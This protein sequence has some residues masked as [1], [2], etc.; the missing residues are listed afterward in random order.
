MFFAAVNRSAVVPAFIV[1]AEIAFWVILVAGLAARYVLGK[2]KLGGILLFCVPLA[3]V[4][5]VVASIVDLRTGGQAGM[6]HS[7]AA[8]YLGVSIGFGPELVRRADAKFAHRFADGRAPE[9]PPKY[10]PEKVRYEW[11]MWTRC[12]IALLISCA[13]TLL[14]FLLAEASADP[15]ALW[16]FELQLAAV[17]V[18]WLVC[19]PLRLT[20][21]PPKA[22]AEPAAR[23]EGGD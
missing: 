15:V 8:A 17:T 21:F 10:G 9:P 7:L 1:G 14:M 11:R 22:P 20:L 4:V 16:N 13:L 2:P 23:R 19:W 5:L 3:D 18:I 12:L 6:S